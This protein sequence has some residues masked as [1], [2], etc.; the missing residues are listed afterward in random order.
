MLR[1]ECTLPIDLTEAWKLFTIDDKKQKWVASLAHN[2]SKTGGSVGT[3]YDKSKSLSDSSSIKLLIISFINNELL[4]F[5]VILNDH[6]VKSVRD[7]DDD[8]QE[9]IQLI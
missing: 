7:N 2:I 6:F 1:I 3:N 9:I 8:L 4:V 5:K